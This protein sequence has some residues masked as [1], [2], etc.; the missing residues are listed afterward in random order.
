MMS[1][2]RAISF[3]LELAI[4]EGI[5]TSQNEKGNLSSILPLSIYNFNSGL[6]ITQQKEQLK[7]IFNSQAIK[8]LEEVRMIW[9]PKDKRGKVIWNDFN[10]EDII[11]PKLNYL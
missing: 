5:V 4:F 7:Q 8:F 9:H 1:S 6:K 11:Y 3:I 10:R 2:L